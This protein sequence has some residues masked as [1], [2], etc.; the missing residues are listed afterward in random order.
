[1]P[2]KPVQVK[3]VAGADRVNTSVQVANALPPASDVAVL[4]TGRN[5]PDAL[6]STPLA[7]ALRAPVYLT[8]GT[9]LEDSVLT[10]LQQ[11]GVRRVVI[12]GGEK[13]VPARVASTLRE[14][15]MTVE[16]IAGP[17]R[18][19]TSVEIA[20]RTLNI[21]PGIVRVMVTTGVSFPDA[22]AAGGVSGPAQSVTVLT[23]GKTLP[24]V[25]R[26]YLRGTKLKLVAIGGAPVT[27]LSGAGLPI[28]A[29][30]SGPDR[31]STAARVALAFAKPNAPLVV[32]SG[33]V[34]AD[35]LGGAALAANANGALLLTRADQ[36]P[37]PAREVFAHVGKPSF[38]IVTG[39]A[40]TISESVY[41]QIAQLVR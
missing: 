11:R 16:R 5:W 2:S 8:M 28:D 27:A 40:K 7:N 38:V 10:S 30:Y 15:G 25:V 12:I 34:F 21:N 3:R 20:K 29:R 26:D 32:S 41:A 33:E 4:C 36:L 23:N 35:A 9:N 18:F 37:A 31:Y 14:A 17:D 22:L 6:A 1:M 24:P 13:S 19:S 39:G